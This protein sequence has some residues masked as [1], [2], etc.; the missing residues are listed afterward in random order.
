MCGII[1]TSS[2][3]ARNSTCAGGA[4]Q[5]GSLGGIAK[6]GPALVRT[7]DYD[8]S[9]TWGTDGLAS[10]SLPKDV[11]TDVG[12]MIL[13]QGALAQHA[14][15]DEQLRTIVHLVAKLVG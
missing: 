7:G 11:G 2:T 15:R 14:K 9:I 12:N 1:C 3:S 4:L 10:S 5:F 8:P 6:V 13:F